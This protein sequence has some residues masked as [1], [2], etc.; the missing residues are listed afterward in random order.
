MKNPLFT[1][2]QAYIAEFIG[3]G[4]LTMTVGLSLM[5]PMPQLT[6][7]A[8]AVTVGIFVYTVGPI[9]GAH[10]N[11]AVTF[12]LTSIGRLP[13]HEMFP[14]FI[15][16]FLG[17]FA[18]KLSMFLLIGETPAPF[19]NPMFVTGVAEGIGAAVLTFGIAAFAIGKVIPENAGITIG[20][21]LLVGI[22]IASSV[23]NGVLNPAVAMG[24]NSFSLTYVFGPIIGAIFGAWAYY[25][26]DG[27]QGYRD[28]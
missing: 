11:P 12:G 17:A 21:S 16:Q 10:L 15:A 18:A 8:A 20:G 19:V 2:H 26:M 6:P 1:N 27:A 3:T 7:L 5:G 9:S 25:I 28:S 4:I 13:Y 24:I 14:Y 23:S 22:L